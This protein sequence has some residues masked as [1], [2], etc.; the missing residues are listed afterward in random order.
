M[1][2]MLKSLAVKVLKNYFCVGQKGSIRHSYSRD[3]C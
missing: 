2:E 3:E 1:M